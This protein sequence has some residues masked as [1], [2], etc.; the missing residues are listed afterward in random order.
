MEAGLEEVR[1]LRAHITE[2]VL[3]VREKVF[4]T[5]PV[6]IMTSH[7]PSDA[8]SARIVMDVMGLER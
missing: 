4:V 6:W 2:D 5:I 8:S 3:S 1:T 7:G